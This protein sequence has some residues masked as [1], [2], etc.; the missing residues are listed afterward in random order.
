ML[1]TFAAIQQQRAHLIHS[2]VSLRTR[3]PVAQFR[4]P[5]EEEE[6]ASQASFKWPWEAEDKKEETVDEDKKA[7][8]EPQSPSSPPEMAP[9]V[10]REPLPEVP[11]LEPPPPRRELCTEEA[12]AL[13]PLLAEPIF[14]DEWAYSVRNLGVQTVEQA[15]EAAA[16]GGTLQSRVAELQALLRRRQALQECISLHVERSLA[17]ERMALLHGAAAIEPGKALPPDAA[18]LVRVQ[19]HFPG[20]S[21]RQVRTYVEESAPL[22]ESSVNGR[23]D[24]VQ[25]GRLYMGC[26]QFGYFL[27]QVFR[28]QAHLQEDATLSPAEAQAVVQAIQTSTRRMKSEA[29]WA[30][31]SRRAG[32]F[33]DISGRASASA[34]ESAAESAAAADDGAGY[35]ELRTFT[36]Q[37]QVVGAAQQEEFFASSS[38]DGGSAGAAED[39]ESAATDAETQD[40]GGGDPFALPIGSFVA[41]NTAGLQACLAE[42]CLFGWHLW[43]A[44]AQARARLEAA[45]PG[46]AE[47]LLVPP[48]VEEDV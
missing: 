2:Q 16:A 40:G 37:V 39:E 35:E 36:T 46:A 19:Q 43:G 13:L 32:D 25:A 11:P 41:F 1:C 44:E 10:D 29:A 23:F 42:A 24:R 28:G 8:S 31:A 33:F 14:P 6:G 26:V 9:I 27:S 48:L 47:R 18:T 15:T 21:A 45:A 12:A 22:N 17:D 3:L 5:W 30:V 38:R 7:P 4:W 20:Q 34:A